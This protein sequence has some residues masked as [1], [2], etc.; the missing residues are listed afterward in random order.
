MEG[1]LTGRAALVTG[2]SRG[3]GRAI[4]VELARMGAN[5]AIN[6]ARHREEAMDVAAEIERIGSDAMV[7][8]ADVGERAEDEVMVRSVLEEFG[9]LDILVN[10]AAYSVRKPLLEMEPADMERTWAVSLW[11]AFHCSQFAARIMAERGGGSILMISSVHASRPYPNCSAY[12]GAKAAMNQMALTWA[13]ELAPHKIRVNVL[14]PGWTDTPGE[15]VYY[16]EDQI[17]EKGKDLLLGRLATSEEV[18]KTAAFL[19]SDDAS[20]VTGSVLRVDGGYA[21]TH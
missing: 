4:A 3:I 17:T 8:Q 15:R 10:N 2:A 1:K 9:R 21:I 19:V 5:V 11:G 12:N 7:I 20:Y 14:E 16:S 6:Y 13:V 18:A